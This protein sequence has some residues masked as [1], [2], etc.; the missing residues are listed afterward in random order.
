MKEFLIDVMDRNR[1]GPFWM[2]DCGN[3]RRNLSF[4][5]VSLVF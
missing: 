4:D 1:I 3:Q 2:N 5:V